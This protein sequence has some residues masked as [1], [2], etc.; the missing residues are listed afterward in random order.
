MGGNLTANT[1]KKAM[2]MISLAWITFVM[3]GMIGDSQAISINSGNLAHQILDNPTYNNV[4]QINGKKAIE[5]NLIKSKT[6][7]LID[8]HSL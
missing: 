2:D 5:V 4:I 8:H 1:I 3:S 7:N 6:K